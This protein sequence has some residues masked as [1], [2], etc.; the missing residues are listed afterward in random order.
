MTRLFP[1]LAVALAVCLAA[2]AA[3]V[4]SSWAARPLHGRVYRGVMADYLNNARH[5]TAERTTGTATLRVS[6]SGE[7]IARFA[8]TYFYYCGAGHSTIRGRSIP[9]SA[10]GRFRSIAHARSRYGV[11]YYMLSGRFV[12]GGRKVALSYLSDFVFTGKHVADPYSTAFHRGPC[13]SWVHGTIAVR[14]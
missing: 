12:D 9:I 8:G 7:K 10:R 13:E 5:W 14:R 3:A 1:R 2:F 4:T 6:A 11:D